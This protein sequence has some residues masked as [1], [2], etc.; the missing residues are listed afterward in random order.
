MWPLLTVPYKMFL[1]MLWRLIRRIRR[2]SPCIAWRRMLTKGV[3][4]FSLASLA[5]PRI[6]VSTPISIRLLVIL[7]KLITLLP[8]VWYPRIGK[9]WCR[10]MVGIISNR[11]RN[12]YLKWIRILASPKNWRNREMSQ[13]GKM[14]S[15]QTHTMYIYHK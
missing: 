6:I 2:T 12:R 1:W 9:V 4:K 11:L 13:T 15:D 3:R 5:L 14:T 8:A 10:D 7:R